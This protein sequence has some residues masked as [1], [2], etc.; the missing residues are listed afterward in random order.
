MAKVVSL[1][2]TARARSSKGAA[3]Q[4]VAKAAFRA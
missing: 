4:S 2:A 3:R 1:N